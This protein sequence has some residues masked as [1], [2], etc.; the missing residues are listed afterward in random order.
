[1][2][3]ALFI[4]YG[5]I[6]WCTQKNKPRTLFPGG[7]RRHKSN[8]EQ[9]TLGSIVLRSSFG[10]DSLYPR[11]AHGAVAPRRQSSGL[12]SA[13]AAA[14]IQAVSDFN[15]SVRIQPFETEITDNGTRRVFQLDIP[16]RI[17]YPLVRVLNTTLKHFGVGL[18][19]FRIVLRC[20]K[21]LHRFIC[22]RI[23]NQTLGFNCKALP[24]VC[25]AVIISKF[26]GFLPSLQAFRQ[27]VR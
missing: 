17:P 27:P 19:H 18:L 15:H 5:L 13:S 16:Y 22:C 6:V 20:N 3:N 9:Y 26:P 10:S 2:S 24:P 25:N 8:A 11:L 12:V 7:T 1:M 14:V 21:A 23:K 4:V